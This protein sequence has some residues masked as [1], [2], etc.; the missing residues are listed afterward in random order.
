MPTAEYT[1]SGGNSTHLSNFASSYVHD[2]VNYSCEVVA[3]VLNVNGLNFSYKKNAAGWSDLSSTIWTKGQESA[4]LDGEANQLVQDTVEKHGLHS[5]ITEDEFILRGQ[6]GESRNAVMEQES[7]RLAGGLMTNR[8]K[9]LADFLCTAGNYKSGLTSTPSTKWD[10]AS[11]DPIDDILKACA[12][13]SKGPAKNA[14]NFIVADEFVWYALMGNAKVREACGG[15]AYAADLDN[16]GRI[17]HATPV[18]CKATYNG[19]QPMFGKNV[20]I[21]RRPEV[22]SPT[23]MSAQC[24]FRCAINNEIPISISEK[25]D[26]SRDGVEIIAKSYYKLFAGYT[27][28]SGKINSAYL[29]TNVI[30]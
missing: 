14:R 13:V 26:Q 28:K 11:G 1:L 6:G 12:A 5:L 9:E 29:F 17:L 8:E 21:F 24:S 4:Q 2:P 18:V 15:I 22:V 16:I 19:D 3:P 23:D 7:A 20:V 30:S 10:N 27:D 25:A